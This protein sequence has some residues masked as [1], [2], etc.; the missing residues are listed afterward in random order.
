MGQSKALLIV[1]GI[2]VIG[3][4][5]FVGIKLFQSVELYNT[6]SQQEQ[7]FYEDDGQGTVILYPDNDGDIKKSLKK[8]RANNPDKWE[9]VIT[10][11]YHG[12]H[13]QIIYKTVRY[14]LK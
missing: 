12:S 11:F 3:I 13:Y 4:A 2:I 9:K 7:M 5:I 14:P 6:T 8:W 1:L 10:F